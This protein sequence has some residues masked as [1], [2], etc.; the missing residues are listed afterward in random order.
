VGDTGWVVP[1]RDS[2]ALGRALERAIE[3]INDAVP[4]QGR[5]AAARARIE[6]NF[7]LARMAES[8]AGIWGAAAR[9]RIP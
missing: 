3:S 7:S 9:G 5:K 2:A 6:G 8:Y 4:F 1:A